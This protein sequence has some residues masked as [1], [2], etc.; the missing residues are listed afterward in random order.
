MV[1]NDCI[2]YV[3]RRGSWLLFKSK[4]AAVNIKH[5]ISST[6]IKIA[7]IWI[8]FVYFYGEV[9]YIFSIDMVNSTTHN[10]IFSIIKH[11]WLLFYNNWLC[12]CLTKQHDSM[13][14]FPLTIFTSSLCFITALLFTHYHTNNHDSYP[15]LNNIVFSVTPKIVESDLHAFQFSYLPVSENQ[16][17]F[18][19]V[20]WL[21]LKHHPLFLL[22]STLLFVRCLSV[23]KIFAFLSFN[24]VSSVFV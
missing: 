6:R 16:P 21:S 4:F 12:H 22:W 18:S 9:K 5:T 14:T 15:F 13:Y 11:H 3:Y 24:Y 2:S 17:T 1:V 20:L 10:N 7:N 23:Y 19:F 8:W